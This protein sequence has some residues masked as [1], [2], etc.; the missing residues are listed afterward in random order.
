[1]NLAEIIEKEPMEKG[2]WI[3]IVS[4]KPCCTYYFGPSL[5]CSASY[6]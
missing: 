5:E 1:M 2:W 6:C 3:E 4:S